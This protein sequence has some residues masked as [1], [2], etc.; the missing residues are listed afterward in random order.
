VI[1]PLITGNSVLDI[2]CGRGRWGALLSKSH[3]VVGV[4][5]YLPYLA[6]A[7]RNG[8]VKLFCRDFEE[9]D[10]LSD[11]A[12]DSFDVVL[13]IEV[14]EHLSK[15]AG[16]RLLWSLKA[17]GQ[18]VVVTTPKGYYPFTGDI[19]FESHKSGWL[20]SDFEG[21]CFRVSVHHGRLYDYFLAVYD[22]ENMHNEGY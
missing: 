6:E 11:F 19:G 10:L 16:L 12:V 2:G 7:K 4:D 21:L 13:C 1:L 15:A 14:V 20:Q 8:Y 5:G 18:R 3:R 17:V 22:K 9:A